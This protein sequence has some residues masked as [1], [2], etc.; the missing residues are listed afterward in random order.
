MD[1]VG[2]EFDGDSRILDQRDHR[3]RLSPVDRTHRVEKMGAH[4]GAGRNRCA[5]LFV[6]GL[7]MAD[8]HH[9]A[10]VDELPDRGRRTGTL[11]SDGHH[12]DRSRRGG[13]QPVDLGRVRVP[14]ERGLMSTAPHGRQPRTFEVYAV[15]QSGA[16]IRRQCADL[17][18]QVVGARGDQRG[19]H[20]GGAVATVQRHGGRRIGRRGGRE[21]A[22]ATAVGMG[23]DETR[24]HGH[25][26]QFAIGTSGRATRSHR[27]HLP[28]R[29][30]DPPR[31]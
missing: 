6:G 17:V 30:V 9:H 1:A 4:R 23:V 15:D 7:G 19:D 31:P 21:T 12:P 20:G 25:R 16:D 2:D 28:A 8:S 29:Q 14:H 22:P 27:R 13:Q 3:A 26:T 11:R 10:G 5:G 24:H 18:Q